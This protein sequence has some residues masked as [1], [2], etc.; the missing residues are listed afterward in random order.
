MFFAWRLLFAYK[1]VIPRSHSVEVTACKSSHGQESYLRVLNVF[2]LA[3]NIA[4][5]KCYSKIYCFLKEH[6]ELWRYWRKRRVLDQCYSNNN[7]VTNAVSGVRNSNVL[8]ETRLREFNRIAVDVGGVG[9]WDFVC[10]KKK[11]W[12]FDLIVSWNP[13]LTSWLRLY[14]EA[15]YANKLRGPASILSVLFFIPFCRFRGNNR[16]GGER[17]PTEE[18]VIFFF[19]LFTSIVWK[20]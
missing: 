14:R 4:K 10:V 7:F 18:V 2:L 1:R 11:G 19:M 20:S 5:E 16:F 6:Y 9:D 3:K 15:C 13:W 12:H 17:F 8:L